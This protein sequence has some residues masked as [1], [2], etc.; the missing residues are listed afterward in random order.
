MSLYWR[1]SCTPKYLAGFLPFLG[2]VDSGK[3]SDAAL[4]FLRS[5]IESQESLLRIFSNVLIEKAANRWTYMPIFQNSG[6][7][8]INC[9]CD[10]RGVVKHKY[11]NNNQSNAFDFVFQWFYLSRFYILRLF[12]L[13]FYHIFYSRHF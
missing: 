12:L 3:S 5:Q 11:Q 1:V 6:E 7:L 13:C 4:H 9:H 2:M 8:L 10:L